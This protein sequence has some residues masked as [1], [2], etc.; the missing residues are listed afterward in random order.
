MF[1][2]FP[3][4]YTWSMSCHLAMMSGGEL[5]EMH[6]W[7]APL[8]ESKPSAERWFDAWTNM[9]QEQER[10]A[11][12]EFGLGFAMGAGDRYIRAS[13]YHQIAERQTAPGPEK[14]QSY[15]ASLSAFEKGVRHGSLPVERVEIPSP[16]GGMP[17][18]IVGDVKGRP[19]PVVIFFGGFDVGKELIYGFLRD[20]FARR[21]I[22]C[23]IPDTPGVGEMLRLKGVPSRP[24]YEVPARAILDYIE[25]RKELNAKR[26]GVAGASLGGYYA[27]RAAAFE[28]RIRCC[29]A[30]GAILDWGA[31]W[32]KR[33][34]SQSTNVSVP[35]FQLPWVMGA[36]GMESALARVRQWTLVDVLPK[37]RQPFLVVHGENDRQIPLLDAIKAFELAGSKDK[38]MRVFTAKE[39]GAEHVQLDEPDPARQLIA[40]WAALKLGQPTGREG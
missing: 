8:R 35:W 31:N 7:L 1:E 36:D 37:M 4:N 33:W 6:R 26:V 28:P 21:G 13:V 23:V 34:A 11:A 9:A 20:V 30:W 17:T 27:P 29:M 18:Y 3:G 24:D 39:G 40:D 25:T 15:A 38:Y 12:A 32:E 5:G 16:D 10:L 2:Y 19:A 22:V 14:S